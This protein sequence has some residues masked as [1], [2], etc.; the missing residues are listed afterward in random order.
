[1]K[2][3]ILIAI[4]NDLNRVKASRSLDLSPEHCIRTINGLTEMVMHTDPKEL[5]YRHCLVRI[6]AMAAAA[7]EESDL[8]IMR[9][10]LSDDEKREALKL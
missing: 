8:A 5:L 1:M 10:D 9:S 7:L 4:T 3:D 2:A 6:A